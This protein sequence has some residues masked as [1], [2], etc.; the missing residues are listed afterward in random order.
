MPS[1]ACVVR[2]D[3]PRGVT[4]RIKYA[5]A[6]GRQVM[7]TVGR[8]RDGYNRKQA[9]AD[10]RERLVRVDRKQYRRPRPLTF[11]AAAKRWRDEVGS[12]KQ[13]RP[14][15]QAQYRSIACRL[16]DEFGNKRLIDVRP[17]DVSAYVTCL[18]KTHSA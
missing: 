14:T 1:G 4:W 12:R 15:T 3:G 2:Y 10:L 11:K 9:E 18:L 7:E 17:A 16:D 5:D 13:W 6:D 8:E